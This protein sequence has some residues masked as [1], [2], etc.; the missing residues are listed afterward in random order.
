[1]F[2]GSDAPPGSPGLRLHGQPAGRVSCSALSNSILSGAGHG[3]RAGGNVS[4]HRG[5]KERGS[6]GRGRR[7]HPL[8]GGLGEDPKPAVWGSVSG[9]RL[10]PARGCPTEADGGETCPSI[11]R[12]SAQVVSSLCPQVCEKRQPR[13]AGNRVV[14]VRKGCPREIVRS[15]APAVCQPGPSAALW[16]VVEHR[17]G[18]RLGLGAERWGA[19]EGGRAS[20]PETWRES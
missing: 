1:M 3:Q 18:H 17:S 10:K 4:H 19:E 15:L 12:E 5:A 2:C 11:E 20:C 9:T 13:E 8:T 14:Q 16:N 7:S 6:R